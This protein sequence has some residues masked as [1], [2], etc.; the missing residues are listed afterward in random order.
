MTGYEPTLC[1]NVYLAMTGKILD[2]E[3]KPL[4]EASA[5]SAMRAAGIISAEFG[6]G[7]VSVSYAKAGA[8]PSTAEIQGSPALGAVPALFNRALERAKTISEFRA[9]CDQAAR[10]L[11]SVY[12]TYVDRRQGVYLEAH[13]RVRQL[14]LE[15]HDRG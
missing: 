12:M 8:P 11:D 7:R 1:D 5:A 13:Q 2:V 4:T 10:S 15:H 9:G 14:A 3:Y 6:Y